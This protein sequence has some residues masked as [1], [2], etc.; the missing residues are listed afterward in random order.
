MKNFFSKFPL[1]CFIAVLCGVIFGCE[2]IP[3]PEPEPEP[4]IPT[5]STAKDTKV[6]RENSLPSVTQLTGGNSQLPASQSHL[7]KHCCVLLSG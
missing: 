2:P 1:I 3:T 4:E 5:D 6:E 7:W